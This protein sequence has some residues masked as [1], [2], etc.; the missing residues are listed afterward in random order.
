MGDSTGDMASRCFPIAVVGIGCRM[1][2]GINDTKAMWEALKEGRECIQEI[3][4][5]RWVCENFYDEDQTRQGKM[6]TKRCGFVDNVN[7]FDNL[8]FKISPRE[9][10]SMDPQQR[11]LLEVT[12]EAFEDAGIVP[13]KLGK[14]CGVF[15]GIGMM[16]HAIQITD[17]SVTDAYTL[18][19]IAHSV[20]SNRISYCFDF[21]GPSYSVDTACASGLTA[22]HLACT[23]LWNKECKV[24]LVA[25]CNLISLPDITVAFSALGVLSPDGRCSPF[26][27]TAN[28]YVRSEGWNSLILKPLDQA[29][30]DG[31]HIYTVI[32]GSVI[33]DNGRSSSLTMPSVSAMTSVMT[34]TYQKFSIPMSSVNFLEAHGT[35]TPVGDPME[36]EAIGK[37]FSPQRSTPLKIGSIK[38]NFGHT[39]IAAGTASAI[40][41][42]LMMENRTLVPTINFVEP[43]DHIDME[44][45]KLDVLTKCEP[46]TEDKY[47]I[48]LNS[49]GFAGA[50]AHCIFEEPP[51]QKPLQPKG[52]SAGWTFGGNNEECKSI[53]VPL[54]A[55]SP[56]AL[57]A[58]AKQWINFE[59]DRDAMSVVAWLATHRTHFDYRMSVVAS[60]GQQFRNQLSEFVEK[61]SNEGVLTATVYS[62]EKPKVCIIFPGQGQQWV[63]MGRQLYQ[64]EE[65]F[66]NSID[67]CDRIFQTISGWSLLRD[68]SL[69]VKQPDGEEPIGTEVFNDLEVSQPAILFLQIAVYKLLKHWGVIPDV[70][71]G[72]SLGEVAAAYACGG[73]TLEEALHVIYIRSVEQG[74]LKGTGSMAALRMKA[75]EAE[76]ICSKYERLYIAAFNA[77]GSVTMAGKSEAIDEICSE[78]PTIARKLRVTCAF[79][80]PDMDPTEKTFKEKMKTVVKTPAGKR[81]I[82]VYSTT[83]GER[84]DGDFG[85]EYWWNNIR[86]PVRFQ[87]AVENILSDVQPSVFIECAASMTLLSSINAIAKGVGATSQLTTIGMGQRQ[88]NDR[89]SA[90]RA[91]H[92]LHTASI[93]INWYNITTHH[94][95]WISLPLYPWQHVTSLTEPE[96]RRKRRLGLDDRTY[97]GQNGQLTFEMFPFLSEYVVDETTT[98]PE[99]GLISYAM[100]MTPEKFP[101]SFSNVSFPEGAKWVEVKSTSGSKQQILNLQCISKDDSVRVFQ[102]DTTFL[103]AEVSSP[104]ASTSCEL[105]V[106]EKFNQAKNR[107]TMAVSKENIYKSLE[108]AGF[109][110]GLKFQVIEGAVVG[111]GEVVADVCCQVDKQGVVTTLLSACFQALTFTVSSQSTS[112]QATKIKSFTMHTPILSHEDHVSVVARIIDS[113]SDT[114]T[115]DVFMTCDKGEKIL[116]ELTGCVFK[117][118]AKQEKVHSLDQCLHE[119][120]F[121]PTKAVLPPTSVVCDIFQPENLQKLFPEEIDSMQR[122]E[123]HFHMLRSISDAYIRHG[124][125]TVSESECK[126]SHPLYMKRLHTIADHDDVVKIAYDDI[127]CKMNEL[128]ELV[129]ELAQEASMVKSLGDHFPTTLRDPPTAMT[130]LFKPECMAAYFMNSLTTRL[131]YRAGAEIIAEALKVALTQKKVV[132]ILEVGA[133]MGGLTRHILEKIKPLCE[134]G[135]VEYVFTDLSV[136]F[137]PHA[138]ETLE[139]YQFVKYQQLDIEQDVEGQGFVPASFDILICLD[140]LHSTADLWEGVYHMRNLVADDGWLIL[141]EAT[142]FKYIA[143]LIF[144]ALRL[145]WI[146]EDFRTECCWMDQGAW[147]DAVKKCG[148]SDVIAVSSPKK[149]FHSIIVGKKTG[150]Y[151]GF[152]L[153]AVKQHGEEQW[154]VVGEKKDSAV[155]TSL[156]VNI[157]KAGV[158]S[159]MTYAEMAN[160]KSLVN[161]INEPTSKVVSVFIWNDSDATFENLLRYL[162]YVEKDSDHVLKA[163]VIVLNSSEDKLSTGAS[164]VANIVRSAS[165]HISCPVYSVQVPVKGDNGNGISEFK[166][167]SNLLKKQQVPHRE[168][169]ITHG[170]Y[171]EPKLVK[172]PVPETNVQETPYW[173]FRWLE[174]EESIHGNRVRLLFNHQSPVLGP[175]EVLVKLKAVSMTKSEVSHRTIEGRSDGECSMGLPCVGTVVEVGDNV[176]DFRPLDD[177]FTLSS[178][179][180]SHIVSSASNVIKISHDLNCL[181][182][183]SSLLP[184][185]IAYR[186]LI[187]RARL[188]RGESL[189]VVSLEANITAAAVQIGRLVGAEVTCYTECK[190]AAERM[191]KIPGVSRVIDGTSTK[192]DNGINNVHLKF[193]VVIQSNSNSLLEDK[194]LINPGGRFCQ[195][196]TPNEEQSKKPTLSMSSGNTSYIF[197]DIQT[198]AQSQPSSFKA[199]LKKIAGMLDEGFLVPLEVR[200]FSIDEVSG[201]LNELLEKELPSVAFEVPSKTHFPLDKDL[202]SQVIFQPTTCYIISGCQDGLGQCLARW[203]CKNGAQNIAMVTDCQSEPAVTARNIEFLQKRGCKVYP[204][205][206]DLSNEESTMAVVR[207]LRN[208]LPSPVKFGLVHISGYRTHPIPFSDVT[209]KGVEENL[210]KGLNGLHFLVNEIDQYNL[211]LLLTLVPESCVWGG[212]TDTTSGVLDAVY[213]DCVIQLKQQGKT[214]VNIQLPHLGS[215]DVYDHYKED[216]EVTEDDQPSNGTKNTLHV[217]QFLDFLEKVLLNTDNLPASICISNQDWNTIVRDCNPHHLKCRHL[218]SGEQVAQTECRLTL[219]ELETRVREK[220]GDLLCI[221]AD[222]I[223]LNQPMINYGIDSLMS[224]EMVTWASREWG[225]VISQLDI[226]G[227]VTTKLLLEKAV[228]N[229]VVI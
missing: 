14:D 219:E 24:G 186:C 223:D 172:L 151:E 126:K 70:V 79:H 49:F 7:D 225:V 181:A 144:G 22:M 52:P 113:D 191:R 105:P 23:S 135:R 157:G 103:T 65:V 72:H 148:F 77:P 15:V 192:Q 116:A 131:Y 80:T 226:L 203:L 147:V 127:D 159:K 112:F 29:M 13:E 30:A 92:A 227:G 145:C 111:D 114:L 59:S 171:F 167:L 195:I 123:E 162:K 104:L 74:K 221:N 152:Q 20:A 158:I 193:D 122:G 34:E 109:Q 10:A 212:T 120:I 125:E 69:F 220:L 67:E 187:E 3:P 31:D 133:R 183:A 132:R 115:G 117:N 178:N 165:N 216:Y 118:T 5:D 119:T 156:E 96:Y 66:R 97:K 129:P 55:K 154:I 102:D 153:Q 190:Q 27:N 176:E 143:E 201:G 136:A 33:A 138:R 54:S 68:R 41:I 50:L 26:S 173:E 106:R 168:L 205:D 12:W 21:Q 179:L 47:I 139:E 140:T 163:W 71:V 36:A 86:N 37:S 45:W 182:S 75:D 1:P 107:C 199:L 6:V 62:H 89:T 134:E 83:T 42:A 39:E 98:F 19:G 35:G 161:G 94:A 43:S 166:L 82:P 177:V 87:Q 81:N 188:Q 217:N 17:T 25:S 213:N 100:E 142:E 128:L 2:G 206:V 57:V 16:D 121:Q 44:G 85:T 90:L 200:S 146:F 218:A 170:D 64:T 180:S 101:K 95:P 194:Q 224:V 189:L 53:V 174:T 204:Y 160:K 202:C 222:S 18:T 214:A 164:T 91:L 8:F 4:P 124:L 141:Y 155:M 9:A 149:L 150:G 108:A 197:F 137:F 198:L 63:D 130:R 229:K 60:S 28:G 211:E 228:E 11:H 48:G 56:E 46:F 209:A 93:P 99:S 185:A 76:V 78:N 58:V 208:K 196:A 32:K 169:A 110:L 210:S 184:F 215:L 175:G 73:L 207:D 84:H 88:Q 40:K 61:G 51:K 38:G